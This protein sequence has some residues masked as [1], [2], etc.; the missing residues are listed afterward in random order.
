MMEVL[1]HIMPLLR[2]LVLTFFTVKLFYAR[3][4]TDVMRYGVFVL[5]LTL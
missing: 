5:A 2:L 4:L 1:E 3:S